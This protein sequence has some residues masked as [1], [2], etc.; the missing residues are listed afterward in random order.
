MLVIRE[1]GC[2]MSQHPAHDAEASTSRASLP[3]FDVAAAQPEQEPHRSGAPRASLD[4]AQAEQV[5]C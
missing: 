2:V 1:D 4:E 5:L 3:A